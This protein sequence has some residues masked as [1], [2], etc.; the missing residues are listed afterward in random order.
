VAAAKT[1]TVNSVAITLASSKGTVTLTG[2]ATGGAEL[3]LKGGGTTAGSLVADSSKTDALTLAATTT[4]TDSQSATATAATVTGTT[5]VA[6]GSGTIGNGAY[7]GSLSG[8]TTAGD[9]DATI[10][11]PSDDDND[12]EIVNGWKI[13]SVA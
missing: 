12:S 11:G 9:N 1:L 3:V 7:L 13:K 2:A 8:G 4:L 5:I 10:T 6:K